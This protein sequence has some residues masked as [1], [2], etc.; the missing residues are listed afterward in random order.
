MRLRPQNWTLFSVHT[1]TLLTIR[2]KDFFKFNSDSSV[3]K[4]VAVDIEHADEA[5]NAETGKII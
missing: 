2:Y 4:E 1:I 3:E 5:L